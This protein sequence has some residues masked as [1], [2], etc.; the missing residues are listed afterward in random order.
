MLEF[1]PCVN[2]DA[3]THTHK[4]ALPTSQPWMLVWLGILP[5]LII[6]DIRISGDP[7]FISSITRRP[8]PT[9]YRLIERLD[10]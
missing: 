3:G 2:R 10:L 7:P 1:C 9:P 4:W 5:A 6:T 8:N